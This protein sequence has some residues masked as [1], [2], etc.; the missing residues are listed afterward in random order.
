MAG[1]ST[2]DDPELIEALA[3]VIQVDATELALAAHDQRRGRRERRSEALAWMPSVVPTFA[4]IET[5]EARLAERIA[6]LDAKLDAIL[7][8]MR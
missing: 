1:T 6:T 2:P 4:D 5:T 3:A 7:S 8:A